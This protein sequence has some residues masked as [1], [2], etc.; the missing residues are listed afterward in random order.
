MN[1]EQATLRL[2]LTFSMLVAPLVAQRQG[3]ECKSWRDIIEDAIIRK[4]SR[5]TIDILWGN[6]DD[7]RLSGT[8]QQISELNPPAPQE[9]EGK[10]Y[11]QW[12]LAKDKEGN[13]LPIAISWNKEAKSIAFTHFDGNEWKLLG[14]EV[15][16]DASPIFDDP[17]V[18]LSF[19]L[20]EDHLFL[21]IAF[22]ASS[23]ELAGFVIDTTEKSV[24][25]IPLTLHLQPATEAEIYEVEGLECISGQQSIGSG[26]VGEVFV[27]VLGEPGD[28]YFSS[29]AMK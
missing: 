10:F 1:K 3:E 18:Q 8:G 23:F 19:P 20:D 14:V 7:C 4:D 27:C 17:Y 22:K 25:R 9:F 2:G 21:G 26:Q 29:S 11:S 6:Y 28:Y 12:Q 15:S 16:S 13:E 24:E 5:E